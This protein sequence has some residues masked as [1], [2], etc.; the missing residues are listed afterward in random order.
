MDLNYS[1]E[2]EQFRE[3][4]RS[5]MQANLPAG[6]GTRGYALPKGPALIELRRQWQR[7]LYEAGLLGLE[8]PRQYGGQGASLIQKAIFNEESARGPPGRS[9]RSGS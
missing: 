1:A 6:W 8:W 5:F 7:K 4:V 3:R 9:I 2:E